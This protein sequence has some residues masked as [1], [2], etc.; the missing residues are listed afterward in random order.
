VKKNIKI[1]RL[2]TSE[3]N[4]FFKFI[5]NYWVKKVNSTLIRKVFKWQHE[6]KDNYNFVLAKDNSKIIGIQGYIPMS[7]YD[8][9]LS[10]QNLFQV[11]LR[12]KEGKYIGTA[13]LLHKKIVSLCDASFVGVVG[14]DEITHKF[15]RWL[16]FKIF[17]MDHHFLFSKK[18]QKF[19]VAK[20]NK[21]ILFKKF[22]IKKKNISYDFLN[23]K[24]INTKI[25]N[26]IFKNNYPLKSKTY[27]VNRYLKNPFYK[28]L[29]IQVRK[30][31]RPNSIFVIRP[32]K[33]KKKCIIRLI[34]FIGS[35][36]NFKYLHF[37]CIDILKKFE[38]EYI[39]I[40][41]HGISK[42]TFEKSG[43]I[44]RMN[45]KEIII[46]N[47]FEPFIKKNVDIFCAYKTNSKKK[48]KLFKGDGDGDRP[49]VTIS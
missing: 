5:Q 4:N 20:L 22:S 38:A 1:L 8:K 14:I 36:K 48:I 13:V 24:N 33:V 26:S 28:Y 46:P 37:A 11:F 42:K 35:E 47:Y 39:D 6:S 43:F 29:I 40:Y 23:L 17:K 12:V 31:N 45:Y 49:S 32:I 7:H 34:D 15:H 30:A 9:A 3:K 16:G 21:K 41:S 44:N 25:D 27:L 10:K 19:K 18:I 2:R